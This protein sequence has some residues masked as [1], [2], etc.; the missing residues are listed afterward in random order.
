M[1]MHF[2]ITCETKYHPNNNK[3]EATLIGENMA[4]IFFSFPNY[5][6]SF[7]CMFII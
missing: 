6:Q 1:E 2:I 5:I 7:P 3:G 4:P